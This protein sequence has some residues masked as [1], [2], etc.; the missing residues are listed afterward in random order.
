MP[1]TWVTPRI[2]TTGERVGQSKMNE[3]SNDLRVLFPYAAGGDIAYRDPAGAYLTALTIGAAGKVFY[4]TGTIP[5]WSTAPA[6][7]STQ[8]SDGTKPTFV[9]LGS[10]Y[11]FY[12]ATG[13]SVPSYG[14]LI[15]NRQGGS[16]TNWSTAGTTNYTETATQVQAGAISLS[17]SGGVGS[18]SVTFPVAFTETPKVQITIFLSGLSKR[19][20]AYVSA[21]STTACTFSAYDIDAETY[22]IVVMWEATAGV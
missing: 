4:S 3:I 7:G 15:K 5:A 20:L 6:A 1:D 10:A 11:Q 9:A 19:V 22:S 17:I 13:A 16:S 18:Q 2:W 8:T 21:I 12:Q 14:A